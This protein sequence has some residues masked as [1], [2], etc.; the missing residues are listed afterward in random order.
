LPPV[1][2]LFAS[3]PSRFTVP[4][5][6]A[7]AAEVA[8][9][10]AWK[11]LALSPLALNIP[12]LS[13]ASELT[14]LGTVGALLPIFAV[15]ELCNWLTG[16]RSV[17]WIVPIAAVRG[18]DRALTEGFLARAGLLS[19]PARATVSPRGSTGTAAGLSA[20]GRAK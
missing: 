3:K 19:V 4:V 14:S 5:S 12:A 20:C 9:T 17:R 1:P 13:S 18:A 11:P 10:R 8:S 7:G 16:A 6:V 2:P 15:P